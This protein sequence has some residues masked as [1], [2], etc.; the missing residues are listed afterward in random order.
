MSLCLSFILFQLGT[1]LFTAK[2]ESHNLCLEIMED[3]YVFA[4][5]ALFRVIVLIVIDVIVVVVMGKKMYCCQ[6]FF[7]N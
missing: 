5:V 6:Y 3:I 1:S 7:L 2:Q 4:A